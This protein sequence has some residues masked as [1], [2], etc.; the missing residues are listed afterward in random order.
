MPQKLPINGF[1][2]VGN[3]SKFNGDF[4]KKYKLH[5]LDNDLPLLPFYLQP[6]CTIQKNMS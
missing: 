1:K 6:T 2:W 4:I 5:N 3:I